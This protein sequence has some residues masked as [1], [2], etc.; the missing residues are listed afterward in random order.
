[1]EKILTPT[2]QGFHMPYEHEAH[3]CIWMAWPERTD[4]WRYGAK[5]A[6]KAFADVAKAIVQT[7]PVTMIVSA[8][9]YQ[10]ARRQLPSEIKVIEMSC[11]DSWMRDIGPSYVINTNGQRMGIDWEF[12]AWGDWLMAYIS[13][14]TK[15]MLLHLRSVIFSEILLI[16]LQLFLKVDQ[17]M[18]MAMGHFIQ[19][20]NAY[21]TQVVISI[22]LKKK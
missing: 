8:A 16:E 14:G 20:K 11:D 12:N 15:M 22:L 10:N 3:D 13:L 18:L 19:R 6:Q 7:T 2:E 21:F 1:M 17:F 4:N 5:L 9:Q